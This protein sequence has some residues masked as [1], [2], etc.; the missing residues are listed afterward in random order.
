[1]AAAANLILKNAA[2][3]NV[4][5][6]VFSIESNA[7]EWRE[8]GIATLI[9]TPSNR[10]SRKLAADK[11]NGINRVSGKLVYPEIAT[12]GTVR[13]VTGTF[14]IIRPVA[15]ANATCD[16]FSA[17][18]KEAIAQAIVSTAVKTGAIPT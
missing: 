13:T 1:M 10:L 8:Q 7:V 15:A 12:D 2:A 18:F 17:R 16:E 14:E 6:E 11:V 4:T 9:G 3:A 5:F